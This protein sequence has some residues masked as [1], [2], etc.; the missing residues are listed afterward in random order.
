M[1]VLFSEHNFRL[2]LCMLS[3]SLWPTR[4]QGRRPQCGEHQKPEVCEPSVKFTSQLAVHTTVPLELTP[5]LS[6][7][8]RGLL[9]P[10]IQDTQYRCLCTPLRGSSCPQQAQWTGQP[11]GPSW[12]WCS[13][14]SSILSLT[15][16]FFSPPLLQKSPHVLK[17][18]HCV[19]FQTRRV[20]SPSHR[21]EC[22]SWSDPLGGGSS[23][24]EDISHQVI[25]M[26]V[27]VRQKLLCPQPTLES[28][29]LD[30]C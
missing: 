20:P 13:R 27:R 4:T 22:S 16:C 21:T 30:G 12:W 28:D 9:S 24:A 25:L 2:C 5:H 3:I 17:T 26:V 15:V 7:H 18:L 8:E 29:H 23:Q 10:W 11:T 14:S 19:R 6:E 1:T